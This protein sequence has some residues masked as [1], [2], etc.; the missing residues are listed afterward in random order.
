MKRI[1]TLLSMLVLIFTVSVNAQTKQSKASSTYDVTLDIG[2]GGAIS[3]N[4]TIIDSKIEVESGNTITFYID[5][6][7]GY[8]LATL[9]F[10]DEDI[11]KDVVNN[12]FDSPAITKNS[13]I[14][15]TFELAVYKLTVSS[16]DGSSLTFGV[17]YTETSLIY[18]TP[19][20]GKV[21][22]SVLL[23]KKDITNMVSNGTL[24]LTGISANST[25]VV[26]YG[27][28]TATSTSNKNTLTEKVYGQNSNIVIENSSNGDYIN[29]YNMLGKQIKTIESNGSRI[30]LNLQSGSVYIVKTK[31][32]TYKVIL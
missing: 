14:K 6:K 13:T 8:E 16:S 4:K 26:T 9:T 2:T 12:Q 7:T 28:D 25:L 11:K 23:N 29:V 18:I 21:L 3:S 27:E 30:S 19:P 22:I 31:N 32:K 10:N 15:A 1:I 5:P 24:T 17:K 20:T